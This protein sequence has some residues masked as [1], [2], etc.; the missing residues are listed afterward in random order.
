MGG[1]NKRSRKVQHVERTVHLFRHYSVLGTLEQCR[2]CYNLPL[3]VQQNSVYY[4][5]FVAV[6]YKYLLLRSLLLAS[7][8]TTN[9]ILLQSC[10]YA[11]VLHTSL[12]LSFTCIYKIRFLS[13]DILNLMQK[14]IS[15]GTFTE[16]STYAQSFMASLER[17]HSVLRWCRTQSIIKQLL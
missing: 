3:K 15:D 1:W 9:R 13:R 10:G 16:P 5:H 12:Y 6:F 14:S 4:I 8:G 17:F 7:L 2:R 11:V